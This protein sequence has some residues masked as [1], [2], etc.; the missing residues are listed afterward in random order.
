MKAHSPLYGLLG[1]KR[2][3]KVIELVFDTLQKHGPL[4]TVK[5]SQAMGFG[6]T[7]LHSFEKADNKGAAAKAW[8]GLIADGLI[9]K[10]RVNN[11]WRYSLP[12]QEQ[13]KVDTIQTALEKFLQAVNQEVRK[14]SQEEVASLKAQVKSLMEANEILVNRLKVQEERKERGIVERIFNI[15]T[16]A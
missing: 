8:R 6:P 9:L 12:T 10:E 5:L 1:R 11:N 14:S 3:Q 7:A 13:V 16:T 2:A 15:K 4:T